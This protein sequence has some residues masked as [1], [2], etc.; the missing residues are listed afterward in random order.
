MK[1]IVHYAC[2]C[3]DE[4]RRKSDLLEY[5]GT[6]GMDA[7]EWYRVPDKALDEEDKGDRP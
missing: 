7:Q 4:A 6:H 1:W 5:C 2:G 3:T